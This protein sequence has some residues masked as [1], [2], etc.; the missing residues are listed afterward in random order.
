MSSLSPW[1]TRS[2]CCWGGASRG[3]GRHLRPEPRRGSG[4]GRAAPH[5]GSGPERR[6]SCGRGAW[7]SSSWQSGSGRRCSSTTRTICGRAVGRRWRHGATAWPTPPRRFSA[8]PWPG[9][10]TRRGC[11]STSRPAVSCTWRCP[12]GC[13]RSVWSSTATTSPMT[14]SPEHCAAGVGRI[15]VDSFDEIER[16][17]RLARA[18]PRT[19][20]SRRQAVMV[21][22]T[23][24]VEAHTH[25][26]V[27][28]GQ[29]DSKFGFGL[30]SG[31]A[32]EAVA[33]CGALPGLDLV[34]IHAHI[35]S[36]VFRV[37]SF[38]EEVE[39]LAG[40]FTPLGTRRALRRAAA[41]VFP[42]SPGRRADDHEVG[43]DGA[44][45]LPA[46]RDPGR[47]AGHC[48]AR[49]FDRG[50][51][52]RSRS[53]GSGPSRSSPACGPTSPSTAA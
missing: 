13:R 36:Q 30:A 3:A 21:R 33:A 22:V 5:D 4:A 6:A 8:W 9:W 41:S 17:A 47:H 37:D 27:R 7:T 1:T 20:D 19:T 40:F 51:R 42:T 10:P 32:A 49:A 15:V 43:P 24:G 11:G 45:R 26:F 28:T 14:S 18:R 38:A 53:T 12:P 44:R 34:G 35:G 46:R 50:R 52:R 2:I 25:D 23:P 16:L 29:E 48:R 39:V 31:A